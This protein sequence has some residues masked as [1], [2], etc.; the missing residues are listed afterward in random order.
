VLLARAEG[1]ELQMVSA[2]TFG[3]EDPAEDFARILVPADSDI[4]GPEDLDGRSIAVNTLA[5]IAELT[6]PAGLD[7]LGAAHE[8]VDLVEIGFPDMLPAIEDGRVDAVFVIEPF[9]SIGLAQGNR[10]IF[11]PYADTA[12]NLAIGSYFSS[13]EY[14]AANPDV[15]DRF[16]A[17]VSAAGEYI[18]QN[19]DEFRAALP[20]LADLD[21]EVAE[22]VNVP[23]WGG[24][25]D[26]AS[27][28]LIAELMVR[29]DLFDDAPPIADVV[30]GS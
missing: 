29:Y 23:G 15:I 12:P 21:P 26:V 13:D 3:P 20:E 30:Y 5:N 6:I 25:V 8:N 27:V 11:S 22:V 24:P 19:P 7:N 4:D 2:G 28:E 9:V 16:I 18:G 17:G 1:L 10:E 14:I